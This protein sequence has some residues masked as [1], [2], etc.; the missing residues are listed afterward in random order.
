MSHLSERRL[1]R[2]P[3]LG[4]DVVSD[5]QM[6]GLGALELV[7]ERFSSTSVTTLPNKPLNERALTGKALC[8]PPY[9]KQRLLKALENLNRVHDKRP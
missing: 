9:M 6:H 5:G 1:D 3:K 7:Q 4:A 2:F 8:A